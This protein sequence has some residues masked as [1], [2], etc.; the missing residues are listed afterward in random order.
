[1][2]A[3]NILIAPQWFFDDSGQFNTEY[4]F[5]YLFNKV[6][7]ISSFRNL[8]QNIDS[9][10]SNLIKTFGSSNVELIHA[11]K[12]EI[13]KQDMEDDKD[14]IFHDPKVMNSFVYSINNEVLVELINKNFRVLYPK[15]SDQT[16]IDTIV[17]LIKKPESDTLAPKQFAMITNEMGYLSLN[18]FDIKK[19]DI[20]LTKHYNDDFII[21]HE[22]IERFIDAPNKTGLVLLH[23][24]YGSGKTSY[25]RYLIS[26]MNKR[27]IY[28]PTDLMNVFNN[29]DFVPFIAG[30][31]N[32]VLIIEDCEKMITKRS[33]KNSSPGLI[34]L[35]NMSD[36]LLGDAMKLKVILTFN[37]PIQ[38]IDPAL[39]RKGRMVVRYF[40]DKL[41]P[42]KSLNLLNSLQVPIIEER[43]MTL[44]D[45]Y[46]PE[47]NEVQA[48]ASESIGF[49]R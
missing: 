41:S 42:K 5:F 6:P 15:E 45:I 23:G 3:N 2:I 32:S 39:M 10:Q 27:F 37:A 30:F 49:L 46:N 17:S 1:M 20:Q 40:F 11:H 31:P 16:L 26:T 12:T 28:V 34:N 25:L 8:L 4:Y 38:D 44:A 13:S 43:A 33:L 19:I 48:T 14:S 29:P 18:Y 36:G 22:K 21:A 35:L 47:A 9:V 7:F 24:L